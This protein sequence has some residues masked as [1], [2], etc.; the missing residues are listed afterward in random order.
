MKTVEGRSKLG[1]G[2]ITALALAL[3][4]GGDDGSEQPTSTASSTS[5]TT[6]IGPE[7]TGMESTT[8]D[9]PTTTASTDP[10]TT[11]SADSSDDGPPDTTGAVVGCEGA[12]WLV[13]EDFEGATLGGNPS[14]WGLRSSGVYGGNGMG[15]T[16][17]QSVSGD[18]SFRVNGGES[19]AQWLTYMGDISAFTDGHWGRMYFRMGAPVPWP[20]GGVIHGDLFEARG[21]WNDSTHQVRWAVIN[22]PQMQHNWGYNVQTTNAG[23]F[24]YETPYIYSWSEDWL[25]VEWHH[26][27]ANQHA[28]LWVDG[29][30][31][32]DVP[33]GDNPQLPTFDDISV[34]WA[35]YQ[36]ASPEFVVY[37]DDVALHDERVG[38]DR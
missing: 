18:Q 35:N 4:C 14:G 27:Q 6:T 26:D 15:A 13:C 17:E 22:N 5:P 8:A 37:I 10:T 21:P 38:C 20:N 32:V 2:M 9:D 29:E 36:T 16:D 3:A 1:L 24:I 28:T 7:T 34:G 33:S 12:P 11:D 31:L 19:G 25:C 23:E 30:M